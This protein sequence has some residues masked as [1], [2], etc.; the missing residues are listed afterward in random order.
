MQYIDDLTL[1]FW[2]YQYRKKNNYLVQICRKQKQRTYRRR[3]DST[4]TKNLIFHIQKY[5]KFSQ[6]DNSSLNT[7]RK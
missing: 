4:N 7:V 5:F 3:D 6:M 1:T 2:F